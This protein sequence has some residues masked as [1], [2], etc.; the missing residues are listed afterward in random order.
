MAMWQRI[1]GRT[2]GIGVAVVLLL[3]LVVARDGGAGPSPLATAPTFSRS[4]CESFAFAH[5]DKRRFC[6]IIER[7]I[8]DINDF[9]KARYRW[10]PSALK[11]VP[12]RPYVPPVAVLSYHAS[13]A[14][15]RGLHPDCVK[16]L[17][18]PAM[19]CSDM[20]ISLD[21]QELG[22]I[23]RLLG[24]AGVVTVVAHEWGHHIQYL[25]GDLVRAFAFLGYTIQNELQ[26]DCY[27]GLYAKHAQEVSRLLDPNAFRAGIVP[28]VY[29]YRDP[30]NLPW[31]DPRAHGQPEQRALAFLSGLRYGA[32]VACEPWGRY[33]G[34]PVLELGKYRLALFP[35]TTIESREGQGV[36]LERGEVGAVVT[37]N[38]TLPA[39]PA[40]TQISD[41]ARFWL[42]ANA[43]LLEN[44]QPPERL[45]GEGTAAAQRY[46]S[47]LSGKIQHGIFY[48]HI[49]QQEGGV[50]VFI[51]AEGPASGADWKPIERF[52]QTVLLGL[53]QLP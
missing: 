19:Y 1:S 34:E 52:F 32:P 18:P 23:F 43:R 24:A 42:G 49:R 28:A 21:Q 25:T 51:F 39:R 53:Q 3:L 11:R 40:S 41:V 30:Q 13:G 38:S 33:A 29:H 10:V 20:T 7:A 22:S 37:W 14:P 26:A 4:G 17:T 46:Q 9:W 12:Y 45:A 31:L 48:L 2:S 47:A 8:R 35:G 27:A 36:A 6:E 15:P 16:M 5:I 44:V 50:G